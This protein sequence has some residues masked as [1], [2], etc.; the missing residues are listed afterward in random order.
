MKKTAIKIVPFVL[1]FVLLLILVFAAVDIYVITYASKYIISPEQAKNMNCIVVLG[2]KVKEDG[3]PSYMLES[4]L[5]EAIN[6][7]NSGASDTMLMSG[8][9]G[10]KDYDEVNA[11]MNYVLEHSDIS[12]ERIFLDHAGFSTYESAYRAKQI[13]KVEKAVYVTQKYHLYRAVYNARKCGT[14]AYGVA[15][16]NYSW[17]NM[18]YYK[19]RESLAIFKDF[20]KCVFKIKPTYLGE[21][22]SVFGT[23][24][25]THDKK[26]D[27]YDIN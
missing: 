3:S 17:P 12:E 5:N 22:I 8:D 21:T 6:L 2:A 13:F 23:A 9:H 19:I 4:R 15:S 26:L 24:E 10:Q 7:Y 20:G 25:A 1:L 27:N 11:M 18:T 16:D 14:E